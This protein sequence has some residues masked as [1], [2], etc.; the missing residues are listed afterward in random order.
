M[1]TKNY[2]KVKNLSIR[3]IVFTFCCIIC[4]AQE[5]Q[6]GLSTIPTTVLPAANRTEVYLPLLSDKRVGVFSNH[7]SVIGTTHLIDTLLSSGIN[8][9]CIYAPEHGFRGQA[10]AGAH[11]GDYIDEHTGI[12]VISLYGKKLKPSA[13]DFANVDLL[14][15]DIQDVGCR[16]YTYISSLQYFMEAAF[17]QSKPLMI[18]D[19]PNPNGFYI[20]GPVL[21]TAYKSFVGMQ[22]IPIVYG[23]TIGEYAMMIAGERWLQSDAANKRFDYYQ[24]AQNSEDTPFHFQVIKCTNYTH[25]SKY[26]LPIAP[27]PNLNS[28]A[29]IYAYPSTC[30]FEGTVLSEGRGTPTPFLV[31]GHPDYQKFLFSF[32][33]TANDGSAHPKHENKI[34]YGWQLPINSQEILLEFNSQIQLKYIKI[35]YHH[36]TQKDAFF[37]KPSTKKPQDFFFNKLSGNRKLKKQIETG[38]SEFE[39]RKSWIKDIEQFKK[40]RSKYLCYPD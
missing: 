26:E 13:N 38:V 15:F 28:M 6:S 10:E 34:C 40:I 18:L 22:P 1:F 17:E 19:R 8:V 12:P 27:S 30:L 37:I 20:D 36:F 9:T 33:P 39:I 7:T 21:D 31:F 23:M 16:F 35:A 11:T 25:Q 24:H 4:R 5:I 32:T 3:I 14:V 2:M 29:A